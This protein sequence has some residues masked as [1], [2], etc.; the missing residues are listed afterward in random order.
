MNPAAGCLCTLRTRGEAEVVLPYSCK[1]CPP[2]TLKPAACGIES[3]Q[4]SF[5]AFKSHQGNIGLRKLTLVLSIFAI[6]HC[7]M[8]CLAFQIGNVLPSV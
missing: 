7:S 2:S 8:S 5:R 6:W 1:F 4:I 3:E